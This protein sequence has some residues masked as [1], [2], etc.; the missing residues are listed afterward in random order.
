MKIPPVSMTQGSHLNCRNEDPHTSRRAFLDHRESGRLATNQS[1]VLDSVQR[2]PGMTAAELASK[3]NLEHVECQRRL[4]DLNKKNL[5]YR[6]G[7]RR[8]QI[9]GTKMS[10]WWPK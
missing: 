2:N 6:R 3:S 9:K 7:T 10:L 5:L 1:K 8:C 4:S